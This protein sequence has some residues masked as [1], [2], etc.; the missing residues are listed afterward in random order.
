[1]EL[2]LSKCSVGRLHN[3]ILTIYS[4]FGGLLLVVEDLYQNI[5]YIS[6]KMAI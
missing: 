6:A 1:L 3:S 2:D 4:E 5:L